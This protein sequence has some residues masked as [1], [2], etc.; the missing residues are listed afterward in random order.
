M[1]LYNLCSSWTGRC[2]SL[3]PLINW[4]GG[5]YQGGCTKPF[6]LSQENHWRSKQSLYL[7]ESG[8]TKSMYMKASE[9]NSLYEDMILKHNRRWEK[10][11]TDE[12]WR[13]HLTK[14]KH[15]KDGHC[16]GRAVYISGGTEWKQHQLDLTFQ[17][18][19]SIYYFQPMQF[20]QVPW[21]NNVTLFSFV[22][23]N[24]L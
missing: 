17:R 24:Y 15:D 3:C 2:P 6:T 12:G 20:P 7:Q 21:N 14:Q 11:K 16:S 13:I 19:N 23:R 1:Q 4:Q 18:T 10:G 22:A 8:E 9:D 5:I